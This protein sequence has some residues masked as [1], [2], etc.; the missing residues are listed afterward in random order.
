MFRSAKGYV[1]ANTSAAKRSIQVEITKALIDALKRVYSILFDAC[2]LYDEE[3]I[4]S[5]L[6]RDQRMKND[7]KIAFKFTARY[8]SSKA[9]EVKMS[10]TS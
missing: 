3:E 10:N 7:K 6:V 5:N 2:Q 4:S 9:Y 8:K 1:H